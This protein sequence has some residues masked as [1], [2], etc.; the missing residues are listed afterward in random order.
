MPLPVPGSSSASPDLAT[1]KPKTPAGRR[2]LTDWREQSVAAERP[3][4]REVTPQAYASLDNLL[5]GTSAAESLFKPPEPTYEVAGE[6]GLQQPVFTD[7]N[8][9]QEL[10]FKA[11]QAGKQHA[12]FDPTAMSDARKALLD[13]MNPVSAMTPGTI[14]ASGRGAAAAGAAIE[15]N[16]AERLDEAQH[17]YDVASRDQREEAIGAHTVDPQSMPGNIKKRTD[18]MT[19]A[20]YNALTPRQRAAVD[21]NTMLTD[22]VRHDK[23][24]Q[25]WYDENINPLERRTYDAAVTKMFGEDRGSDLYAPE[26]MAVL[27]QVFGTEQGA[28]ENGALSDY[29]SLKATIK[30]KDLNSGVL[31]PGT[32]ADDTRNVRVAEDTNLVE[33]DRQTLI[34]N[35]ARGTQAMERVLARGN[36]LLASPS[37]QF[38]L[39]SERLQDMQRLGAMEPGIKATL[40]YGQDEVSGYFQQAFDILSDPKNQAKKDDILGTMNSELSPEEFKAFLAYADNRSLM[41]QR[42]K[43]PLGQSKNLLTADQFRKMLGLTGEYDLY[44]TEKAATPSPQQTQEQPQTAQPP[45]SP[46]AQTGY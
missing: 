22:A 5:N 8:Y 44:R 43:I 14:A 1:H 11:A 9:F 39:T 31:A 4:L 15:R 19:D 46:P 26:T 45:A 24:H 16:N 28:D 13:A 32:P 25:G 18:E 2:A 33:S 37:I 34:D 20:E 21:F 29:T 42:Y 27:R 30:A 23:Q 38:A 35:L 7:P 12:P 3:S 41:A 36:A 6:N 40:G 10:L 17:Q